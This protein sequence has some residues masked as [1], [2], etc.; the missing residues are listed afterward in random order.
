MSSL[1]LALK[2]SIEDSKVPETNEIKKTI[3][4]PSNNNT[5]KQ[6]RKRLSEGNSLEEGKLNK[7]LLIIKNNEE[8]SLLSLSGSQNNNNNDIDLE[9]EEN[10]EDTNTTRTITPITTP[11]STPTPIAT[12]IITI[13][14]T[15]TI[16]NTTT[17]TTTTSTTNNNNKSKLFDTKKKKKSPPSNSNTNK[18]NNNDQN[19]EKSNSEANEGNILSLATNQ[20]TS[21]INTQITSSSFSS[22]SLSS[23]K[24]IKKNESQSTNNN[25]KERP[26]TPNLSKNLKQER[27]VIT[28]ITI[29]IYDHN[30]NISNFQEE[31]KIERPIPRDPKQDLIIISNESLDVKINFSIQNKVEIDNNVET[32]ATIE[33]QIEVIPSE[34]S[35]ISEE[36]IITTPIPKKSITTTSPPKIIPTSTPSSSSLSSN[37][38][39]EQGHKKEKEKNDKSNKIVNDVKNE[40]RSSNP[41]TLNKSETTKK[42]V[43]GEEGDEEGF[44]KDPVTKEG[45][46]NPPQRKAGA[47]RKRR[48]GLDIAE[49]E[50]ILAAASLATP[51]GNTH[52][53][54]STTMDPSLEN[55]DE[56]EENNE[57]GRGP[58]RAAAMAAKSKINHTAI[59][60][61][62]P[63]ELDNKKIEE[64]QSTSSTTT[65][66]TTT[67]I[68]TP[69][70]I[71]DH[72]KSLP[73]LKA[74]WVACDLCGKWRSLPG[75]VDLSSLPEQWYCSMNK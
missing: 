36:S 68:T 51:G 60:R 48:G 37:L 63:S 30:N 57:I 10:D 26:K 38:K 5:N 67:N 74:Q 72:L 42:I 61:P 62:T 9:I 45:K 58:S 50:E 46:F 71:V 1:R 7:K 39:I 25:N 24:E 19:N 27:V 28:P 54:T 55:F 69:T 59:K 65:S 53:N 13:T 12:T 4:T 52:Q 70:T 23:T 8:D 34:L 35:K 73:I 32:T 3:K 20:H 41:K 2:L 75:E 49:S 15:P 14:N 6:K 44:G 40:N 31:I 43:N 33:S 66:T 18:N 11:I 64:G 47:K 21:P 17:S 29:P 22:S 56:M 16:T